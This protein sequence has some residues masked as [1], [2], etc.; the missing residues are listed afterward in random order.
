MYCNDHMLQA[1]ALYAQYKAANAVALATFSDDALDQAI[2]LRQEYARRFLDYEDTGAHSA[3]IGI[4]QR[5]RS[6]AAASSSVAAA[7]SSVA[8]AS[9]SVAAASSSVAAASSSVAAAYR[10]TAYNR[11][12]M[13]SAYFSDFKR[14]VGLR[15]VAVGNL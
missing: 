6:I 13:D 14:V 10:R 1:N 4:L 8:A 2:A 12:M 15:S 5:V 7:S 3:Y 11:W 9:S